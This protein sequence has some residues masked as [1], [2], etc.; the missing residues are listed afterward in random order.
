MILIFPLVWKAGFVRGTTDKSYRI[1][2]NL[3]T[4][5]TGWSVKKIKK[6]INKFNLF[7]NYVWF[8]FVIFRSKYLK[9]IWNLDQKYFNSTFTYL[10][11]KVNLFIFEIRINIGLGP[12]SSYL[13]LL[14]ELLLSN[15]FRLIALAYRKGLYLR[16]FDLYF[17]QFQLLFKI[18][19]FMIF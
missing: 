18:R 14:T 3:F 8:Y 9:N 2:Y 13:N 10:N 7:G 6:N 19:I 12:A 11:L 5:I 16:I 1:Y 17:Y 15:V 4:E